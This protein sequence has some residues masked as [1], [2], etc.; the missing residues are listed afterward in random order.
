MYLQTCWFFK[1]NI[2]G[3]NLQWNFKT[4][5]I[6]THLILILLYIKTSHFSVLKNSAWYSGVSALSFHFENVP[7]IDV[8]SS[9]TPQTIRNYKCVINIIYQFSKLAT[10]VKFKNRSYLQ[11]TFPSHHVCACNREILPRDSSNQWND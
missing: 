11:K 5:V 4:A 2:L 6:S 1:N 8:V 9:R 10:H 3:Y 7:S